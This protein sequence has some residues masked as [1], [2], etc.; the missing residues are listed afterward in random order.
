MKLKYSMVT[1][2]GKF[3]GVIRITGY[4]SG[5]AAKSC[6]LMMTAG[7]K[8]IFRQ[9]VHVLRIYLSSHLVPTVNC[10]HSI[11]KRANE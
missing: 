11:G 6:A 8:E 7:A 5:E 10:S 2:H 1:R 3:S 4:L 9:A